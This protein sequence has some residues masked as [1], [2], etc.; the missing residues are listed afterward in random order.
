MIITSRDNRIY[1][2]LRLLSDKRHRESEGLFLIEGLRGVQDALKNGMKVRTVA[3]CEGSEIKIDAPEVYVLAKK[4]F[5]E[6][7]DTMA[8][9]GII[10]AFEMPKASLS[11][12]RA[13]GEGFIVLCENLRDPGNLGTVIRT[14]DAA[15]AAGVALSKG[16]CDLFNP[17]T[18]RSTVASIGNIPI[19]RGLNAIEAAE[20]LKKMGFRLVAGA[21]TDKTVS[22]YE[23]DL[24]GKIAFIVG[25]EGDGISPELLAM[26]DEAVKI[27]MRGGAESLNAS[28][29]AAVMMYEKVRHMLEKNIS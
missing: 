10:A 2:K 21:L 24:S 12:F 5:F 19:A 11:D 7:A 22:L 16:C 9:Q 26:A 25:N 6:L 15:G 17:K 13:E 20:S 28:V 29:A 18:V 14:A 1:K 23:A 27:P 3:L 4:L 8:P